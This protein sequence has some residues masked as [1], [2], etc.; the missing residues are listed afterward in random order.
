MA[1]KPFGTHRYRTLDFE[2]E[3]DLRPRYGAQ[4]P[5]HPQLR[6]IMDA[7]IPHAASL[8]AECAKSA[9]HLS[10][11]PL[12]A[13]PGQPQWRNEWMPSLD[14]VTLSGLLAGA[15]GSVPQRYVEIGSGV[16]TLFARLAITTHGLPTRIISIDPS[17]FTSVDA[18]C[19]AVVREPLEQADLGVF[20]SVRSGDVVFFD[21][22]HRSFQNSD[23]TVFFLDVLPALPPGVI[24]GL[25]DI[26]LPYDYPQGWDRLYLNEQYVLAARLL[27]PDSG[28]SVLCPS[29]YLTRQKQPVLD[30]LDPIWRTIPDVVVHGCAFWMQTM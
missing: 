8:F 15:A 19:D 14:L 2:Y 16:S 5:L 10:Q 3:Y 18:A 4:R 6:Q 25:H 30:I 9:L 29:Y 22:S 20:D 1:N 21:G 23:V 24:V 17:P 13:D 11:V 7:A 26:C 28:L 27:A 12:T